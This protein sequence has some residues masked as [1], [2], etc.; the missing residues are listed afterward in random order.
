LEELSVEISIFDRNLERRGRGG[1]GG[2][3]SDAEEE[4]DDDPGQ[5]RLSRTRR[6]P[7]DGSSKGFDERRFHVEICDDLHPRQKQLT[8]KRNFCF[9]TKKDLTCDFI[10]QLLIILNA[11]QEE[12][13]NNEQTKESTSEKSGE[14][15]DGF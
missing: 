14:R 12:C 7:K 15:E 3:K 1:K 2:G 5:D 13:T 8:K 9:C 4:Y 11:Q 10:P 6:R